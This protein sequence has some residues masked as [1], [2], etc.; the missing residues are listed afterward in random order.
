MTH[1]YPP[2]YPAQPASQAAARQREGSRK[3]KEVFNISDGEF[4]HRLG[5]QA[6]GFSGIPKRIADPN[7][8]IFVELGCTFSDFDAL[9]TALHFYVFSGLPSGRCVLVQ[10]PG[11]VTC[12]FLEASRKQLTSLSA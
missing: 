8:F 10:R 12:F 11:V 7:L 4:I 1:P 5:I 3:G 2:I 9:G 6:S